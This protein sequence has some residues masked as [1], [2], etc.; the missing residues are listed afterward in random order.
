[1]TEPRV[2]G[3]ARTRAAR[4]PSSRDPLGKAA[5]FSD[6]AAEHV[7]S[8]T[9]ADV[10]GR[11]ASHLFSQSEARSGTLVVDC[12]ACDRR[13]RVTY[14]EFAALHLPVWLWIPSPMRTHRHWL[15]CPACHRYAWLRAH[16]LE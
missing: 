16:W 14:A 3:F 4:T 10:E 1:M 9:P 12:S 13:T 11:G 5:L 8:I 15:R 6:A 2:S 7:V